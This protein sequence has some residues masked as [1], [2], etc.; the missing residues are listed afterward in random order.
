MRGTVKEKRHKSHI[1]VRPRL[2]LAL[3]ALTLLSMVVLW[4]FQI[5]MLG[6]F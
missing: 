5:R 2:F 1:G 4:V 3:A 6:Y